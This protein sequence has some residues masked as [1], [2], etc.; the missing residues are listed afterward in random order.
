MNDFNLCLLSITI[1]SE[2]HRHKDETKYLIPQGVINEETRQLFMKVDG[3][4]SPQDF[5]YYW[6]DWDLIPVH[7]LYL[8]SMFPQNSSYQQKILICKL[9]LL[10]RL[11][12]DGMDARAKGDFIAE[13]EERLLHARKN[14]LDKW[15][16]DFDESQIL[17]SVKERYSLY[18]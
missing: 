2:D 11:K 10:T 18:I 8:L 17:S 7:V 15:K 13:V 1:V 9:K 6:V 5:G 16:V 12:N 14:A 3:K 4:H